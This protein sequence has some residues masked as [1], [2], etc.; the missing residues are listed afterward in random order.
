MTSEFNIQALITS[1]LS[2]TCELHRRY[3][4]PRFVRVLEAIGFNRMDLGAIPGLLAEAHRFP[5]AAWE[6]ARNL[7]LRTTR[8]T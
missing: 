7:A 2:E 4:N 5:G 1:R 6:T 3:V 8:H